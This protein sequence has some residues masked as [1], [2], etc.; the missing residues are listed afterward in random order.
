MAAV[1]CGYVLAFR[2]GMACTDVDGKGYQRLSS[3]SRS[4][5]GLHKDA[6]M[7]VL[8]VDHKYS[9]TAWACRHTRAVAKSDK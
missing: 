2:F 1:T 6:C 9:V 7:L 3:S 4:G 8:S 5:L